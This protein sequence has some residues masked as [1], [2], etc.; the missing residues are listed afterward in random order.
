[1]VVMPVRGQWRSLPALQPVKR[2]VKRLQCIYWKY[3]RP[4]Y[5]EV[6]ATPPAARVLVISPHIDDDVIGCGGVLHQHV[7]AGATVTSVYLRDGGPTREAEAH[8]AGKLIGISELIFLRWG[9]P[10]TLG[11]RWRTR[12]GTKAEVEVREGTIAGLRDVVERVRP[13]L[14]YAPFF[15]DPH[16][17]HA[18]AT[19][20]L[21]AVAERGVSIGDCYLY[22]VWSPLVP[23]VLVD[24]TAQA[25]TK[26]RA[27]DTHRSQVETIDMSEGMLG[28]N[29]YRA[30]MN[31]IRG[32]AEAYL[33]LAP[34][35]LRR[36]LRELDWH[37][38]GATHV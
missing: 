36:M 20:L 10:P 1:M 32:Y 23:N 16:P 35:E 15:L 29:M 2:R 26:R 4:L 33:R 12:P 9:P 3:L 31:R 37:T 21:S 38:G 34:Q 7:M 11:T 30:E 22:E 28:L 8:L 25:E 24:I 13:D 5:C 17:D 27:I 6:I 19:R 18:A 14:V